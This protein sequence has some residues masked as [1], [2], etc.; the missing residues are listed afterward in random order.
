MVNDCNVPCSLTLIYF[1]SMAF[2]V[3]EQRVFWSIGIWFLRGRERERDR[4][5]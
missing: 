3:G 4:G 1:G 2:G 5:Q